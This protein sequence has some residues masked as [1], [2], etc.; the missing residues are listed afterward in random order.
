MTKYL[1]SLTIIRT[2]ES[3]EKSEDAQRYFI[4]PKDV[5]S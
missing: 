5:N 1:G 3:L 4:G 2:T